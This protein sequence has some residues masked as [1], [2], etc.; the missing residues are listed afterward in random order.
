MD[1]ALPVCKDSPSETLWHSQQKQ[2]QERKKERKK[3]T[4]KSICLCEGVP[5]CGVLSPVRFL[6]Y[7]NDA[8]TT[9]AKRVSNTLR[10]DDLAISN[11]SDHRRSKTERAVFPPSAHKPGTAHQKL[12]QTPKP[13]PPVQRIVQETPRHRGC[14]NRAA[15][16]S[17]LEA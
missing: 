17:C 16:R 8:L 14:A 7:I 1:P 10:A 3:Q 5:Q 11:A 4:K 9:I 2:L 12:P 13:K 6:V 15:D